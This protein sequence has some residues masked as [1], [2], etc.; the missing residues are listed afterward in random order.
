MAPYRHFADKEALL[1]AVAEYGFRRLTDRMIDAI[2]T[3]ADPRAG[4]V[5]QNLAYFRFARAE[6][7]L[8]KLMFGATINKKSEY[9][10]LE[11]A[12]NAAFGS[13]QRT[14]A[15]TEIFTGARDQADLVLAAWSLIH[16][17]SALAVDGRLAGHEDDSF[18]AAAERISRLLVDGMAKLG[19]A[20]PREAAKREQASS[21]NTKNSASRTKKD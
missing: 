9:P 20:E 1:A 3:A 16:G 14:V 17:F 12:C 2:E 18:E 11:A 8:F 5:A 6:P 7:C 15:N 13:L 4:L 10:A 21:R 19:K